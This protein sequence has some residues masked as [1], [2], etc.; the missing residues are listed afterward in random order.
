MTTLL[1]LSDVSVRLGAVDVLSRVSLEV[2]EGSA[3]GLVGPNGA[4]KST[5]LDAVS[6]FVP[7]A[8]G[9]VRLGGVDLRRLA[10]HR[11]ARLGL[12]RT[13]QSLDLFDDLTVGE[14]LQV[15]GET[16]RG[17]ISATGVEGLDGELPGRLDHAQRKGVALARAVSGG[18]RV[19]LLD[20]P[21]AGLDGPARQALTDR[22]R[23]MVGRGVGIVVA[24]HDL[25]LVLAVCDHV[26][27]LDF[28]RVISA[29]PPA[30]VRADPALAAA[31]LGEPLGAAETP[32]PQVPGDVLLET[33]R[34]TAG[35]GAAPALFGVDLEVREG[36]VVALL[37]P[38][39][40]GKTTT[41]RAASGLIPISGGAVTFLGSPVRGHPARLARAG[42][43]HAPQGR[44]VLGS[45]TVRENLRLAARGRSRSKGAPVEAAVAGFPALSALLDRRAGD[46]SGGEQQI[47][48]LARALAAQPRVLMVDELS[49][50]LA[51][52]AAAGAL[53]A[54]RQAADAGA[55]VLLVEQHPRLALGIADRA[56]VMARGRVV[57]SG[58]AAE[59][60]GR[61]EV[62]E[63]AYLGGA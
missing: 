10:P 45:L 50:G 57:F 24:D 62:L 1:E 7:L 22:L 16:P 8:G 14:N 33:R 27:V 21:A 53:A 5:L 51:P 9:S 13:F 59:L 4:G 36:E 3:V 6:G 31:Y 55:G 19:L 52:R 35:Y 15:A 40:A 63:A 32:A 39:G 29:G 46:L 42:L 38:N 48:A 18:P 37:G 12:G 43:A 49:L 47:L 44:A 23:D 26:C 30:A 20:E 11:R 34:L 17:A 56:L 41:L 60:A 58:T 2:R 54:V 25:D 61:P 28:G